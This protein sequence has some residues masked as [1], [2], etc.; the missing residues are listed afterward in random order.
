[1]KNNK[2]GIFCLANGPYSIFIDN[3]IESSERDFLPTYKKEYFIITDSPFNNSTKEN[4]N[5]VYKE[6]NGWPLDCILRPQYSYELE[7]AT[8]HLD[9]IYFFNANTSI[10]SQVGEEILPDE[11]GLVGVEHPCFGHRN[12]LIFTYDRNPLSKAYIPE[13]EG[14][15]YYQACFWGGTTK[16]FMELSKTITEWA[17]EDLA[18][19]VEPVWLDESYL[20]KYFLM[21]TPK[22]LPSTFCWPTHMPAYFNES[23]LKIVQLDKAAYIKDSNFRYI[24]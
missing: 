10:Y 6:R 24:N 22:T 15:I 18:N 2:V 9:Y 19:K 11:S 4:V 7:E 5:V 21:H 23:E 13:G 3:V 12:N 14:A 1:M 20:N 8:R 16:A 17:N